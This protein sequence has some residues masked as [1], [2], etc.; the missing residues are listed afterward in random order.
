V[1][2]SRKVVEAGLRDVYEAMKEYIENYVEE[3]ML[4]PRAKKKTIERPKHHSG[5]CLERVGDKLYS[6][7]LSEHYVYRIELEGVCI[8][9][10]AQCEN[11]KV[12]PHGMHRYGVPIFYNIV[13]E[14]NCGIHGCEAAKVRI[15]TTALTRATAENVLQKLVARL[16]EYN[17]CS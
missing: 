5:A 13:A 7:L 14:V 15:Y 6:M 10:K 16:R 9:R 1:E 12:E 11:A 8:D 17:L 2:R 3:C 4:E